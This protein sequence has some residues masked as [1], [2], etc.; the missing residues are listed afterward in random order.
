MYAA[1]KPP[2]E[3]TYLEHFGVK[4]MKWGHVKSK[5]DAHR[6]TPDASGVSRSQARQQIKTQNRNLSRNL[7]DFERASNRSTIIR[8]ARGNKLG[9][10][11]RYEDFKSDV[12]AQKA[13]GTLGKNQ[14]RVL[15]NQVKNERYANV[16][17]SEQKTAGEQFL[18]N[19]FAPRAA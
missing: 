13:A 16:Y 2:L 19:F 9:T 4:G 3:A 1:D 12:K 17:K 7:Q 6:N 5:I 15:M 11:R 10:Q 14:A 8:T 18:E